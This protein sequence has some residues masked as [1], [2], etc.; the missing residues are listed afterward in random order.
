[1]INTEDSTSVKSC[2]KIVFPFKKIYADVAK[3]ADARDFDVLL[4]SL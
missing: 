1:M 2:F 4:V 3:M